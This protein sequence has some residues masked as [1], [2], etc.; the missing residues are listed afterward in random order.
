MPFEIPESVLA[1]VGSRLLAIEHYA[2][3]FLVPAAGRLAPAVPGSACGPTEGG[4]ADI[5]V[6]SI[7][8]LARRD[9]VRQLVLDLQR[10]LRSLGW[11][12]CEIDPFDPV[13]HGA[14]SDERGDLERELELMGAQAPV[15]LIPHPD[16]LASLW[17]QGSRG[18]EVTTSDLVARVAEW[19]RDFS[20]SVV[21]AVARG[22]VIALHDLPTDLR[23]FASEVRDLSPLVDEVGPNPDIERLEPSASTDRVD[24]GEIVASITRHRSVTLGF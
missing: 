9:G 7:W 11:G 14:F 5:L 19:R 13:V 12:A 18:D 24:L 1:C 21:C 8:G 3:E 2:R 23:T 6:Q 10:Q 22:C 20:L 17:V 4:G 15:L 16:D